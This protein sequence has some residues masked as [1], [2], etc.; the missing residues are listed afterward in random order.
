MTWTP[1]DDLRADCDRCAGLCCVALPLSKSA[2]FAMDKDAGVPCPNLNDD[3][4]CRIHGELRERGFPGCVAYDCFGAGQ[5]VTQVTFRDR[6]WRSDPAVA[7]EMQ[8]TFRRMRQVHELR[9]LVDEAM[10]F[11]AVSVVGTMAA[12]ATERLEMLAVADAETLRTLDLDAEYTGIGAFLQIA[13]AAVRT[14]GGAVGPNLG[15]ADLAGADRRGARLARADLRGALLI[16]ADLRDADLRLADLLGADLRGARLHGAD[17]TDA[18]FLT[19]PQV[20]SALGDDRTRLP[21]HLHPP[22]HWS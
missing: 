14:T 18:L 2:D 8:E 13:S 6:D 15:R 12:L 20:A 17:L 4:R 21:S 11:E 16:G 19:P 7:A 5:R 22:A 9:R 3:F 1:P 10:S